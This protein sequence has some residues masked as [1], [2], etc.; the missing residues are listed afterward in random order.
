MRYT[1]GMAQFAVP[2]F[3][4]FE[5][6]IV[7][8]LTIKQFAFVAIPSFV[9]FLLFFVLKLWIWIIVSIPLVSCGVCFAFI[10]IGGQPLYKITLYAFR[11]FWAPKRFVWKQPQVEMTVSLPTI[12][13][14]RYTLR[15]LI[16]DFS[17][18]TQ[19][20]QALTTTKNPIPKREKIVPGRSLED[21]QEQYQVFR[22]I[23]G[24][25]EVARRIDYR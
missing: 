24:E 20:W 1:I 10:K 4:D 17:K 5:S 15:T 9:C 23:T 6:K 2:Q 7:G 22:K 12:Q 13:Q 11:F 14:K 19:L 8:P 21:V 3:I 18:V 16:P 25:K